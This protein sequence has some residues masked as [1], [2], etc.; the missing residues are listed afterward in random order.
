MQFRG[1]AEICVLLVLVSITLH[2]QVPQ[3]YFRQQWALWLAISSL[4]S[5]TKF[6]T[7]ILSNTVA[8]C[9]SIQVLWSS[10]KSMNFVSKKPQLTHIPGMILA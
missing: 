2:D 6:V 8:G 1:T 9:Q 7:N 10:G 4:L 5:T 3:L